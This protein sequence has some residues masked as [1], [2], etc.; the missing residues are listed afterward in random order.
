MGVKKQDGHESE[1]IHPL[2]VLPNE[3]IKVTA[4]LLRFLEQSQAHET[5]S[6]RA[7]RTAHESVTLATRLFKGLVGFALPRNGQHMPSEQPKPAHACSSPRG[8]SRCKCA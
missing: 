6:V 7:L 1:R 8:V 4:F 5:C 3:K 2:I